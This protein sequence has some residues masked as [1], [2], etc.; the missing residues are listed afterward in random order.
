M[1]KTR[2]FTGLSPHQEKI[3][4]IL[5]YKKIEIITRSELIHLIK[6]HIKVKDVFDLIEKLQ[7]KKNLVSLQRGIYMVIPFS[8]I[9]KKWVL[10]EFRI[11]DYLLKED[12]YIGLYHAFHLHGFTEQIPNNMF[13][14]NTIYS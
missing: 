1:K 9:N 12:Y 2:K 6:K 3:M 4:S 11:I 13:V 7:K 14:F 8:A 10:D 5:T